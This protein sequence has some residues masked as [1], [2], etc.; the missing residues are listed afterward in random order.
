MLRLMTNLAFY[1]V[2]NLM[3]IF[4]KSSSKDCERFLTNRHGLGLISLKLS[5]VSVSIFVL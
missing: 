4:T 1:T 3:V 5:N 2:L